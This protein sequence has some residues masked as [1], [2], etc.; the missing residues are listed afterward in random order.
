MHVAQVCLIKI[1]KLYGVPFA[2]ISSYVVE[3]FLSFFFELG[4]TNGM[5]MM[6]DDNIM[7]I[8]SNVEITNK[9]NFVF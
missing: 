9:I 8:I 3:N 5:T 1:F 4:S 7:C 6:Y 2:S